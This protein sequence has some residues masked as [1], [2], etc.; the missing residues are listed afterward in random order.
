[1]HE[2]VLSESEKVALSVALVAH[3]EIVHEDECGRLGSV[4]QLPGPPPAYLLC[5]HP[6]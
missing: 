4:G 5:L 6:D 2:H 3:L 1:M